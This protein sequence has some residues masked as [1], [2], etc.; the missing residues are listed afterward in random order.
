MRVCVCV[1][2]CVWYIARMRKGAW[3]RLVPA[4]PKHSPKPVNAPIFQVPLAAQVLLL[5]RVLLCS[6]RCSGS[7][8]LAGDAVVDDCGPRSEAFL[9]DATAE[10]PDASL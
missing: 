8:G 10:R 5:L 2:V 3:G 6:S 4:L 1:C 9:P 7:E